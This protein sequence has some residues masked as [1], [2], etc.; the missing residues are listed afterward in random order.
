MIAMMKITLFPLVDFERMLLYTEMGQDIPKH[1]S[2]II[3]KI[4]IFSSS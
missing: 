1:R 4:C 3:S 2:I